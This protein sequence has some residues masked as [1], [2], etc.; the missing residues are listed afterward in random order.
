MAAT[1]LHVA[2]HHS[3]AQQKSVQ[4]RVEIA[5]MLLAKGADVGA[6]DNEG[7]T[8][9]H[10]ACSGEQNQSEL[11]ELLLENGA[12]L[13]AKNNDR[14]NTLAPRLLLCTLRRLSSCCWKTGHSWKPNPMMGAP[15]SSE[16]PVQIAIRM[17]TS[18]KSSS[19]S[20]TKAPK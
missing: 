2:C 16:L 18:R 9:L 6:K 3:G 7:Y 4:V 1:A 19:S 12:D 10:L 15:H 17:R 20:W 11:V 5:R 13:E 8:P 14:R